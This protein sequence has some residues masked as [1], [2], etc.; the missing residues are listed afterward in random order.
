MNLNIAKEVNF[1]LLTNKSVDKNVA[2]EIFEYLNDVVDD[3]DEAP[4][5][6]A[7]YYEYGW[8]TEKNIDLALKYYKYS[9]E[10]GVVGAYIRIGAINMELSQYDE[11]YIHEAIEW[12]RKGVDKS[13]GICAYVLGNTYGN[14]LYSVTNQTKAVH[15]Y[16]IAIDL[17]WIPAYKMLAT[18]YR[19]SEKR[20]L[21]NFFFYIFY[22][23][24]YTL[25]SAS[26]FMRFNRAKHH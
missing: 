9:A 6:L 24:A 4:Y 19:S 23:I 21:K 20:G 17:G 5:L 7:Y 18:L 22:S 13:S 10:K 14:T 8:C 12:L 1:N 16:K 2:C 26:N 11:K 25:R 15:F 3:E